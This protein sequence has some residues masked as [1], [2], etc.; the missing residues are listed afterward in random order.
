MPA[1]LTGSQ[2]CCH[3]AAGPQAADLQVR[4]RPSSGI[5]PAVSSLYEFCP[6]S[7]RF[8]LPQL[9]EKFLKREFSERVSESERFDRHVA[10]RLQL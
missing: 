3:L 9:R 1:V 6:E 4:S 5:D 2:E 7:L 10:E 8:A